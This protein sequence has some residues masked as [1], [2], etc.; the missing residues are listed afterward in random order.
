MS[1][2]ATLA[3]IEAIEAIPLAERNLPNSTYEAIGKTANQYPNHQALAF[4]LQA[5]EYQKSVSWT[6]KEFFETIT[7]AANMFHDL[8]VGKD[9]TVAYITGN[10]ILVDGGISC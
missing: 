9:D 7:Q 8:G 10:T 3:D 6:Y 4:F 2:V 1:A 5:T